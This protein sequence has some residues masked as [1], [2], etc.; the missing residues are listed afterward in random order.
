[1]CQRKI[2]SINAVGDAR[3]RRAAG[4][5]LLELLLA[6]ALFGILASIIYGV[7]VKTLEAKEVAEQ[8]AE[9]YAAGRETVLRMADEV[10][11]ALLPRSGDRIYFQGPTSHSLLEFIRMNR[12]GYGI[13][14][15][16]AGQVLVAY[17]I[18]A[19]DPVT[20]F[21]PLVREE[22]HYRTLLE[23][24]DGVSF[25]EP[26][27]EFDLDEEE[28]EDTAPPKMQVN[29]LE[30]SPLSLELNL[31]GSCVRV[32][33]IRFRYYDDAIEDFRETWDSFEEG[34]PTQD[35]LP[36]AVEITLG[37]LDERGFEHLFAT[38]VDVPMARANPDPENLDAED[39]EDG[40]GAGG[41]GEGGG[42]E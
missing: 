19:P 15:V 41:G 9:L 16:R 3:E 11:G 4:F 13:G 29:L 30:C 28:P 35:R 37:L 10:E 32:S 38:I 26:A 42:E 17:S 22:Y 34:G 24:S 20:G 40:N 6:V 7:L 8:R 36:A 27:S 21:P 1:V 5:T 18:G 12:G 25:K 31:P 39:D 33:G 23:E 2:S 14:R